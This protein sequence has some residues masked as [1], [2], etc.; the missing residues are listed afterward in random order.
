MIAECIRPLPIFKEIMVMFCD[1]N[2]K[3]FE[4]KNLRQFLLEKDSEVPFD[5]KKYRVFCYIAKGPLYR[6]NGL[7]AHVYNATTTAPLIVRMSEISTIPLGFALYIDLPDGY[8]PKGCEI[9]SFSQFHYEDETKCEMILPL[10]ES[11]IIF[12]GDYRTKK[13]IENTVKQSSTSIE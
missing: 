9:T 7:S 4:D 10:L 13:E 5:S 8:N 2:H 1:I 12:S 11:N 3:C 6:M